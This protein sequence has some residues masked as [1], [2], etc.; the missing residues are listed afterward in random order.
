[1]TIK[2]KLKTVK[3]TASL[4]TI[5]QLKK[6]MLQWKTQCAKLN[7]KQAQI[8]T[9]AY[10]KGFGDALKG[11]AKLQAAHIK[12]TQKFQTQWEKLCCGGAHVKKGTKKRAMSKA[13]F[14]RSAVKRRVSAKNVTRRALLSK[15]TKART[16]ALLSRR[17][18]IRGNAMYRAH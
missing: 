5:K 17:T 14:M 12:L 2:R 10:H 9:Q 3:K 16:R 15:K 4:A 11:F 7:K 8:K 6:Q 18:N 1:M 13:R